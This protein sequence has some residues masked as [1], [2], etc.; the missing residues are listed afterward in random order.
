L[1]RER[2]ARQ[3]RQAEEPRTNPSK[4][5]SSHDVSGSFRLPA[6]AATQRLRHI[7]KETACH[8]LQE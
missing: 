2:N 8:R 6:G 1:L 7:E 3:R 4:E 5:L